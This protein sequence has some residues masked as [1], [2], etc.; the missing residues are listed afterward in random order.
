[1]AAVDANPL[2][3]GGNMRKFIGLLLSLGLL[4]LTACGGGDHLEIV[5]TALPSGVVGTPYSV[6]M[7]A[8]NGTAPL[9]WRVI[10]GSLPSGLSL[11]TV[12]VISGTPTTAG[13]STF[14]IAVTDAN[15]NVEAKVF[16]LN[17][18]GPAA[19]AITTAS[20]LANGT[21][22]TAYS[23][24]L[25]ASGG[26]APLT[27]TVTAGTLPAGLTLSTAG[28]LSGTPTTVGTSNFTV[29]VVDSATPTAGTASKPF[30]LTIAAAGAP[31]SIVT[32]SPLPAGTVNTTYSTTLTA[33]GGTSP[34]SWAV[35]AGTL[36]AGLTLSTAGVLSG[37]PTAAGTSDFTITVTDSATPTAHTAATSF[38]LTVA[39]AAALAVTTSSLPVE[40]LGSAYSQQLTASGGVGTLTW[41]IASGALPPGLTLSAAGVISGTP[42][43][44]GAG[45]FTAGVADSTGPTATSGS[46]TITSFT[47]AGLTAYT[48]NCGS[49]HGTITAGVGVSGF[50]IVFP[51]SITALNAAIAANTGGMGSLSTLDAPTRAAIAGVLF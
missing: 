20:P 16:T 13:S 26:T 29:T 14:T 35:T 22:G 23:S 2:Q 7:L 47:A 50:A 1:M 46:L 5:N 43:T 41:T 38:S 33:S 8:S 11:S 28:V 12:G 34:Y 17:V 6:T 48:T 31:L 49:C 30:A 51:S 21:V 32:T 42:T 10:V 45:T 27:W 18:T 40:V 24:T 25:T 9:T 4:A 3:K 19:L 15:F 37:T 39:A 36:P 44:A